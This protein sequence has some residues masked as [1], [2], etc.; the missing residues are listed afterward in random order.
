MQQKLIKSI[1]IISSILITGALGLDIWYLY[2][3]FTEQMIP[4]I[5]YPVLWIANIALIIHL[6]AGIIAAFKANTFGKNFFTYGIYTFLLD[7]LDYGNCIKYLLMPKN[8]LN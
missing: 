6:T 5:L 2:S 1:K 3:R 8:P 4:N 7:L